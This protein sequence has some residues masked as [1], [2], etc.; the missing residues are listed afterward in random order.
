MFLDYKHFETLI[1]LYL[2]FYCRIELKICNLLISILQDTELPQ[3]L[4][5]SNKKRP[6]T[7][8]RV[9]F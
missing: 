5:K 2:F 4:T 3:G 8:F 1:S 6:R 7:H 9:L